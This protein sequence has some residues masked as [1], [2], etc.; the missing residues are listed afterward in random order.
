MNDNKNKSEGKWAKESMNMLAGYKWI[1]FIVAEHP[2][3]YFYIQRWGLFF[4]PP[5]DTNCFFLR[6]YNLRIG[7]QHHVI[8][9]WLLP[10]FLD[11]RRLDNNY[12]APSTRLWFILLVEIIVGVMHYH[13]GSSTS[14]VGFLEHLFN[15]YF[16]NPFYT[17]HVWIIPSLKDFKSSHFH[18]WF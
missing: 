5:W 7:W 14:C 1:F 15:W 2:L 4:L 3:R 12:T 18:G 13:T 11:L 9:L 16:L 17:Q 8:S 10:F 6:V